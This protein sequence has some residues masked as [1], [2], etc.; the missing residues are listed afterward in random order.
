MTRNPTSI[1][2][3]S[4]SSS[5]PRVQERPE[6]ISPLSSPISSNDLCILH[7]PRSRALYPIQERAI[8]ICCPAHPLSCIRISSLYN[9]CPSLFRVLKAWS[10]SKVGSEKNSPLL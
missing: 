10:E 7:S 5:V 6:S 9:H 1:S 4:I 8:R 2:A 3:T